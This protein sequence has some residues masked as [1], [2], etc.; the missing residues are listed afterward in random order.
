MLYK[1][2][3]KYLVKMEVMQLMKMKGKYLIEMNE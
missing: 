3:G 1:V 2:K